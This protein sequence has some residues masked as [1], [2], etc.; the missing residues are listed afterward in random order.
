MKKEPE[1]GIIR[2]FFP[3]RGSFRHPYEEMSQVDYSFVMG[4][5]R[6]REKRKLE[7][8]EYNSCCRRGRVLWRGSQATGKALTDAYT[9]LHHETARTYREKFFFLNS[10]I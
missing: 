4:F 5:F 10:K 6:D 3:Y 7:Q 8:L 2:L 9:H 1:D